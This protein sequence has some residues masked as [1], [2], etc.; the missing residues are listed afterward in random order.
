MGT[1]M[2]IC[3]ERVSLPDL[4]FVIL[5]GVLHVRMIMSRLTTNRFRIRSDVGAKAG[6]VSHPTAS[7]Q[8]PSN[9]GYA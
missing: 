9:L 5:A 3:F 2:Q 1:N 6:S 8:L 4:G 7:S